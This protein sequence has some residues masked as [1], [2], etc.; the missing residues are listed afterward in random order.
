MMPTRWLIA[1]V[2]VVFLAFSAS[3]ASLLAGSLRETL[4]TASQERLR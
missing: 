2:V 4:T 1:L 3:V